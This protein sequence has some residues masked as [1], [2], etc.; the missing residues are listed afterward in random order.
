LDQAEEFLIFAA[1]TD[2]GVSLDEEIVRRLL[3]VPAG[4]QQAVLPAMPESLG[5]ITQARRREIQRS[6][7]E[8]NGAFFEAEAAKLDGWAE[9]LKVGL[10]REIKEFDRQIRE[11][12]R[13]TAG[14]A[15][16]QD[17]LAGQK[18]IKALEA[19]RNDKRRSL[20]DAQDEVDHRRGELIEGIE[21]KLAQ[22]T[23]LLP[24]FQVR[25]RL[26]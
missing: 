15:S 22:Q 24:L 20:F 23:T 16:L 21:A 1:V 25:W 6:I 9:D 19:K 18:E 2:A 13:G 4:A 5:E 12:R 10:E 7:S 11:V 26:Q 14:A 8:R 17:K 3:S